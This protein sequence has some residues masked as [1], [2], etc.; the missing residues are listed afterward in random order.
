LILF[1]GF[2]YLLS[3]KYLLI[4][5]FII[6]LVFLFPFSSEYKIIYKYK[7]KKIIFTFW[8]PNENIPGYIKLCIKTWKKI[9]PE[10]EIIILDYNNVR[11]YLGENLF[12]TIICKNM[13][14]QMQ[15]DAI[16]VA[17]LKKYGG[18]W[19]DADTILINR[20]FFNEFKNNELVMIGD[21]KFKTQHIG[22]IFASLN[23]TILHEWLNKIIVNINFFKQINNV[24]KKS[25]ILNQWD[26]LGNQIIDPLIKNFSCNKFFRLDKNKINA[27]PELKYF[28]NS[29]LSVIEKYRLSI[30]FVHANDDV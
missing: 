11:D 23:S 10:Y 27:F 17:I 14:L 12:D 9:L 21:E 2:H 19:M 15:S 28:R 8:E 7:P 26:Y 1:F 4:F 29:S 16:R 13:S 18:I 3:Y 6:Y 25:L 24:T 20:Y 5:S 22:F 30:S